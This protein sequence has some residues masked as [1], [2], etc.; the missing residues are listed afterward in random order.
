MR[1][2]T[3]AGR[4]T[5]VGC[6]ADDLLKFADD[7]GLSMRGSVCLLF[8]DAVLSA[9]ILVNVHQSPYFLFDYS[10]R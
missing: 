10:P 8:N 5:N 4:N 2:E 1:D 3:V 9:A 6:K 7:M